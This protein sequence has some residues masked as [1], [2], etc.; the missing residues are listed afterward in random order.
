LSLFA[1][2]THFQEFWQSLLLP[3]TRLYA[4][5]FRTNVGLDVIW[6]K[7]LCL[8]YT[9]QNVCKQFSSGFCPKCCCFLRL[10]FFFWPSVLDNLLGTSFLTYF[11]CFPAYSGN[12]GNRLA[13]I[14][15]ADPHSDGMTKCK[16]IYAFYSSI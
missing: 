2:S 1:F 9:S 14:V 4:G 7:F 10:S 11:L 5:S 3:V 15:T 8:P 6:L 13:D 16:S 12:Q